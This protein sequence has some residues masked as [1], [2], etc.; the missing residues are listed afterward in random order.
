MDGRQQ[1][2]LT[3]SSCGLETEHTLNYA[4]RLLVSAVCSNC[5]FTWH[6]T[7]TDLRSAY[8]RDLESRIWHKPE[9]WLRQLRRDPLRTARELPGALVRLPV[10]LAREIATV[11]RD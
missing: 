11:L 9:R 7:N 4:G 3:C 2:D 1:A 10:K 8:I 6:H 5:G